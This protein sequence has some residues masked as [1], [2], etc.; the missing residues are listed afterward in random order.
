VLITYAA[1]SEPDID[2]R[3]AA[4]VRMLEAG[5]L[6]KILLDPSFMNTE[7]FEHWSNPLRNA[8]YIFCVCNSQ[9]SLMFQQR[10]A[11]RRWQRFDEGVK[12]RQRIVAVLW[13]NTPTTSLPL[14]LQAA[15]TYQTPGNMSALRR[16][17]EQSQ[18]F[19]IWDHGIDIL[20]KLLADIFLS[21]WEFAML[22]FFMGQDNLIFMLLPQMSSTA[23]VRQLADHDLADFALFGRIRKMAPRRGKDIDTVAKYWQLLTPDFD[24]RKQQSPLSPRE[25]LHELLTLLFPGASALRAFGCRLLDPEVV[26]GF[27]Q[28][29][30]ASQLAFELIWALERRA[31]ID[32]QL[33]SWLRATYPK[34]RSDI[35]R[36]ARMW[37]TLS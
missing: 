37:P 22:L 4:L 30:P 16:C 1:G 36:V 15:P 9:S 7:K 11:Q 17:L 5:N 24:A 35:D 26:G 32:L 33:F 6:G 27:H 13:E 25:A 29:M 21:N 31:L 34:R 19:S 2:M 18:S 10:D 12:F 23:V 8:H 14:L 28:Q 20:D 3:I